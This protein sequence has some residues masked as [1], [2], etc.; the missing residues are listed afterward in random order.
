MQVNVFITR[1]DGQLQNKML[2]L[3]I[4]PKAAIPAEFRLGWVYY[5]TT[6]TAD[7]MFFEIG[8]HQLERDLAS[9]GFVIVRPEAPDRR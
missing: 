7:R 3:P 1:K 8:Q 9:R 2:V 6:S 4:D 5:A